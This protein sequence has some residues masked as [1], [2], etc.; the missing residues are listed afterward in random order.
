MQKLNIQKQKMNKNKVFTRTCI[1]TAL[2][3][4][5]K[6]KKFE[7]ISISEIVNK[8]GVSRMGFY[9]NYESKENIIEQYILEIFIDTVTE[10]E[11]NRDLDFNIQ[12]VITTT[13]LHFQK[14]SKEIKLLL[15]KK[16]NAL[17]YSCYEKCF[18]YL[19]KTT[20]PTQIRLYSTRMF[21]G[22]IYNLEMAW[23]ETGMK[24]TPEQLAKMY[25]RILKKRAKTDENL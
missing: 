20:N 21:I 19:Y 24:E 2:F 25:Y 11:S 4:L 16:L 12:K 3:A 18:Y 15:D 23:I 5:L 1:V 10:I 6:T 22:E 8:A 14:H 9:R 7:N 13:L 17:L